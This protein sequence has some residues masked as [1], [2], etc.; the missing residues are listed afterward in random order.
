MKFYEIERALQDGI[1]ARDKP[2]RLKIE[3]DRG[4]QFASVFEQDIIQANFYSLKENAGGT[5]ARGEVVLENP[6][7]RYS[8]NN[9]A[10]CEVR[11]SFSVGECLA[12]FRRFVFYIDDKGIQDIRGPGRKREAR[13][14]LR[15][16]SAALRKAEQARDWSAP[17]VFTYSV[18]SDKN[19][20]KKSL[21]HLIANRAGIDPSEIESA[22]IPVTLPFVRLRGNVWAELS[23]LAI[24][25][26][27]HLEC[28][29]EGG[30]AFVHSPYQ[31]EEQCCDEPYT[32]NAED[33]FYLRESE[34]RDLYRNTIRLKVNMPVALKRQMI[35]RYEQPPVFYDEFLQAYYPFKY[36]LV[37]EIE[38]GRYE[39]E[40][41]A[42]DEYGRKRWAVFAD[43]ID[44]KEEA[45]NRLE[46]DGGKFTYSHYD[47][48]SHVDKATVTLSKEEDGNLYNA[49]IHGR[50][51]VLDLNRSSFV[52]DREEVKRFGTVALNVSGQYFSDYEV[53][54][55]CGRRRQY[56]DWT[57]RELSQRVKDRREYTVKTHKA[58]FNARVGAR[59]SIEIKGGELSGTVQAVALQYRKHKA[60]AAVLKIIQELR[61]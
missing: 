52:R 23:S 44:T 32:L 51:I 27:C 4:G 43:E 47:V 58:L 61:R 2:V 56:E 49:S 3:I 21:V 26:R 37:R 16:L 48:T 57:E 38:R 31:V 25:Y 46:Y 33:I 55:F 28:T 12:Y 35:W 7:G 6:C 40:Y 59:V 10:G 20:P 24:A 18:V 45:K 8:M 50:P 39:A 22:A 30:I 34:R 54:S 9:A 36:P 19:E 60:F 41:Y 53:D 14:G 13:I 15:D 42:V 17:A 11:V 1:S 29:L 5:S